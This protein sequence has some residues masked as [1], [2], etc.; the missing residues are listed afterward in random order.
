[1]TEAEAEPG[2]IL[3]LDSRCGDGV[4]ARARET[5]TGT[6]PHA[7]HSASLGEHTAPVS[8]VTA[9]TRV[10][11]RSPGSR[12]SGEISPS[13]RMFTPAI[14]GP[15]EDASGGEEACYLSLSHAEGSTAGAALLIYSLLSDCLPCSSNKNIFTWMVIKPNLVY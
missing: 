12:V 8:D 13:L 14:P 5:S 2:H 11:C 15:N 7:A 3:Q 9:A 10:L 4:L 6:R 1:M